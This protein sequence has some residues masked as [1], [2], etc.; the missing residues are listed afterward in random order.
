ML[1]VMGALRGIFAIDP[2]NIRR[3]G[4]PVTLGLFGLFT[5]V[6]VRSAFRVASKLVL[7]IANLPLA[8]GRSKLSDHWAKLVPAGSI[9]QPSL[10]NRG[11]SSNRVR[12]TPLSIYVAVDAR[13]N[14]RPPDTRMDL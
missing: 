4:L 3:A 2:N 13:L 11:I 8:A 9:N 1:T 6:V 14:T 10:S 12:T 5:K 7:Y